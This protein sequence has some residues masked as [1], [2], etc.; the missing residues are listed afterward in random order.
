MILNYLEGQF[1]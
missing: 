1:E